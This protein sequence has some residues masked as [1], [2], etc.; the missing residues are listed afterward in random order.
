MHHPSQP[1]FSTHA[2]TTTFE[3]PR[4]QVQEARQPKTS[5][6]QPHYNTTMHKNPILEDCSLFI[7]IT[8]IC[9]LLWQLLISLL[10]S[11][12]TWTIFILGSLVKIPGRIQGGGHPLGADITREL[13][14]IPIGRLWP[15]QVLVQVIL[16]A[17]DVRQGYKDATVR[18]WFGYTDVRQAPVHDA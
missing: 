5:K 8:N 17:R 13:L 6:A 10:W 2:L 1:S 18:S 7:W 4:T 16:A 3:G 14:L 9:M 11:V 12:L 15:L